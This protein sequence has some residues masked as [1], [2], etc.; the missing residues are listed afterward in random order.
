M[1]LTDPIADMLTR[2][3]NANAVM[4]EKVDVPHST[5]KERLSEI[6]KEEGYIANY[7]VVTDG[8]KKSIRV[9]LKYDGKDRVIKGIKRI[10]KPGRRVYSS[11][12]DMPRVLS[13]LGIAIVSTSKG[14]VTDRV[15]RR[16]NVGGEILAF[17][18]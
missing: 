18:W 8:N 16:E 6:L 4:H 3:R 17:V 15:A 11:V 13:G 7:K 10:S 9:Y 12:E 14:I 5:L 1:Y 2:I